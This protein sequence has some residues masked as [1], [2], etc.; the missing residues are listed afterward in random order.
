MPRPR[1]V[2]DDDIRAATIAAIGKHGPAKL[3]LAHVAAEAGV[4][5]SAIVQRFGS[6]AA[7]LAALGEGAS[8]DAVAAFDEATA[9]AGPPLEALTEALARFA[10]DIHTRTELANHMAM[11]QLDLT[12]PELHAR[13]AAQS[14]VVRRRIRDLLEA[15]VASG[16]LAH[17]AL[18]ELAQTVYTAY[19]GALITWAIDGTGDLGGWIRTCVKAVIAPYRGQ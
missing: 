2:S 1:A 9:G 13:S 7:L 8:R 15:A 4:T 10:G 11:L 17:D 18:D 5:P 14:R 12:D 6:K 3:T 16:E 19:S